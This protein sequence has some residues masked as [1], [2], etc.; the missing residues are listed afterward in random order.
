MK[1]EEYREL[2]SNFIDDELSEEQIKDFRRHLKSCQACRK[3][4]E[5]FRQ[6][7]TLLKLLPKK[8]A[9]L[10]LWEKIET[11]V[12]LREVELVSF[13]QSVGIFERLGLEEKPSSPIQ[14]YGISFRML[15]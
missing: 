9:P 14:I 2:F 4:F 8:E 7:Q 1:C 15:R 6:S 10:E 3:E 12:R 13:Y 5:G 11:R